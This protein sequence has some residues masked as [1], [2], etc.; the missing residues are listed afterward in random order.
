MS[1]P[2]NHHYFSIPILK[3][4]HQ[5]F[6]ARL[7]CNLQFS[8]LVK[9]IVIV[10]VRLPDHSPT[11]TDPWAL[12]AISAGAVNIGAMSAWGYENLGH[13]STGFTRLFTLLFFCQR[14]SGMS[15]P[16]THSA[17]LQFCVLSSKGLPLCCYTREGRNCQLTLHRLLESICVSDIMCLWSYQSF[18]LHHNYASAV[19]PTWFVLTGQHLTVRTFM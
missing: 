11:V 15:L 19:P 16:P 5:G 13:F 12:A 7:V 10:E 8:T 6:R 3:A 14:M 9:V 4:R 18:S 2:D 1:Y 17:G